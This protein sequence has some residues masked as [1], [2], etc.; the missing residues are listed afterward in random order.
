[1]KRVLLVAILL[2]GC[3]SIRMRVDSERLKK[4]ET[5]APLTFVA[6][7][8]VLPPGGGD[9]FLPSMQAETTETTAQM[10]FT[11]GIP[12]FLQAV[13]SAERFK[14]TDPERVV[15]SKSYAAFP[16]SFNGVNPNTVQ[17]ARGWRYARP[18][19]AEKIRNLLEEVDA[20][21]A[22]VTYWKFSLDKRSQ[23]AG[24]ET[25]T[26]RAHLRAWLIDRDGK[27]IADDEIDVPTDEALPIH[28]GHYDAPSATPL[29]EDAIT[30]CA[31]R[32]VA[33]FSNARSKARGE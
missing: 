31:V 2:A 18:E 9:G 16:T 28:N 32:M 11:P 12:A 6:N 4:I 20:D 24:L 21:A 10:I 27:V 17:L 3:A 30:T 7:R 22:L 26:T 8:V 23:D 5:I 19:D 1:M 29:F 25:A 14:V 33:D 15:S 13:R